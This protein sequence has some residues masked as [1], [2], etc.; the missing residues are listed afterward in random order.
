MIPRQLRRPE[1]RFVL[2]NKNEKRAFE[3]QWTTVNN[4]KYN[5]PILKAHFDTGGNYGVIG[6]IGNLVI[7]DFDSVEAYNK[8]RQYLPLT[9]CVRTASKRLIH[10][11]YLTDMKKPTCYHIKLPKDKNGKRKTMIDVI[12]RGQVVGPNSQINGRVYE[13]FTDNDITF[14]SFARLIRILRYHYPE[15]EPKKVIEK[16]AN[17]LPRRKFGSTWMCDDLVDRLTVPMVLRR[18]GVEFKGDRHST[19]P[20]GHDSEGGRCLSY[21]DKMWY[22]HSCGSGGQQGGGIIKLVEL[23]KGVDYMGAIEWLKKEFKM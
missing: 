23:A 3:D 14:I 1:F 13:V 18:L 2:I 8:C 21:T 12:G 5:D 16:Y 20:L 6:G 7:L 4:Y 17:P 22:C 9:F 15:D 11:Y 19:C 10:A